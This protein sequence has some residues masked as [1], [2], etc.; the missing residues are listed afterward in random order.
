MTSLS[1]GISA[2]ASLYLRC[3]QMMKN[4]KC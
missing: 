1:K 4:R 2:N 3:A